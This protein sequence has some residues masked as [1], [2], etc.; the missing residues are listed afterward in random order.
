VTAGNTM[1]IFKTGG[2]IGVLSATVQNVE[3]GLFV[4]SEGQAAALNQDGSA[5]GSSNAAAVD[6]VVSL[7]LTGLG[8]VDH[9]VATGTAASANP[10]SHVTGK[11]SATIGGESAQVTFAGLAPGFVG[12]YQVNVR[13]PQVAAGNQAVVVSVNSVS[14]NSAGIYTR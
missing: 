3:P 8:A 11:V 4:T 2:G 10:L 1:V 7:F 9:V 13:V 12:L 6:S 14:S 5:N